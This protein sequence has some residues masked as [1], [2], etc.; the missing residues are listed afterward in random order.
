MKKNK[1]N[2]DSERA[3]MRKA[4]QIELERARLRVKWSG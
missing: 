2:G 1:K 4:E 3:N